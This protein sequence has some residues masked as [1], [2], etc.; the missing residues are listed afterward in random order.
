MAKLTDAAVR[1]AKPR[2]TRY[3]LAEPSGLTVRVAPKG[4]KSWVWRY[5]FEGRQK[6]LTIGTYPQMS[7]SEARAALALS[8]DKLARGMDPA[9]D[10]P[11][12]ETVA[13]L[14]DLYRTRH[15]PKLRSAKE[16]AR[17]L[18]VDVL[19]ALGHLKLADVTRRRISDLVHRKA[20]SA[21]VSANR[22]RSLLVHLFKSG[23]EW[24]LLEHSPADSIGVVTDETSR[25]SVLTDEQ[26]AAIWNVAGAMKDQRI[27]RIIRLLI[28]TGQRVSEVCGI[29][30]AEIDLETGVWML[31]GERAKNGR[32]HIVPLSMAAK[33]IVGAAM[34]EAESLHLFPAV[35][36]RQPFVHQ[37]SIGQAWRRICGRL[38]IDGINPHDV[39]RTVATRL[40]AL[41]VQ[42]HVI[43]AVL[44][45]VSG[46]RAGVAGIYQR[47]DY[48][49]ERREALE[50]WSAEI[51][52]L[53]SEI[54]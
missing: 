30:R 1:N 12:R 43:E 40:G 49:E 34:V 38:G 10:R 41:G 11:S 45:H 28:L 37:H 5:R 3:E 4:T 44:N 9:D 20:E 51:S 15:L 25:A 47:H 50:A 6:R 2:S 33:Q 21:P 23:V 35:S 18:R 54:A 32:E 16:Q 26:L 53:T 14:V 46:H 27:G 39:R 42:P 52:C 19:P 8:Q 29:T 24:G 36:K 17:R 48:L 13:D 22:L 31:P 7:L